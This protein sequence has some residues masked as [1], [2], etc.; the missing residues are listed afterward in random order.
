M[1]PPSE[2]SNFRARKYRMPS[3]KPPLSIREVL[4]EIAFGPKK[5]ELRYKIPQ[6]RRERSSF[7]FGKRKGGVA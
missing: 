2:K 5:E 6:K 4:K 3:K 1:P 7:S